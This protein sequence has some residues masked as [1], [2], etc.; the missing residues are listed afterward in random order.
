MSKIRPEFQSIQIHRIDCGI[1]DGELPT[2]RIG[3]GQTLVDA[4]RN[5]GITCGTCEHWNKVLGC[6]EGYTQICWGEECAVS[7][8]HFCAHHSKLKETSE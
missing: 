7:E 2:E 5:A 8:D 4:I 3:K 6:L 1:I